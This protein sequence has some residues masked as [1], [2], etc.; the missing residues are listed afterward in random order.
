MNHVGHE[1]VAP[2]AN[3]ES[4]VIA[5]YSLNSRDRLEAFFSDAVV[6]GEN[7]GSLWAVPVNEPR[8]CVHVD[9]PS[10]LDDCY[11]VAQPFGLFHQMSGQKH[12]LAALAD[13]SHQ[14]PDC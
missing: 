10:V 14:V 9:D 3:G 8:R 13:A 11:A 1:I 4:R 2:T 12:G 5:Y 6:R 7:D